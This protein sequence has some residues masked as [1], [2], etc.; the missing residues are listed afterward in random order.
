[1]SRSVPSE[2][3][4]EG[5][6]PGPFPASVLGWQSLALL[7][8]EQHHPDICL[9]AVC[10]MSKCPLFMRPPVTLGEGPV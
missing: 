8:M 9:L 3:V 5:P 4:R 10:V 6:V 7:A 2:A 1:M